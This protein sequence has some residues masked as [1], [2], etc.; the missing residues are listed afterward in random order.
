VNAQAPDAT[1]P[2]DAPALDA[3]E[4]AAWVRLAALVELLPAVLDSQLRRDAGLTHFEYLVLAM[5]ESAP[6]RVLRMSA[7]AARTSATLPRLSHV[8]SRMEGRG[9]VRRRPCPQ[10]GRASNV[11]LTDEG[12]AALRDASPGHEATVR[13]YVFDV[14]ERDQVHQ[15]TDITQAILRTIDPGGTMTALCQRPVPGRTA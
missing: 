5:L 4:A 2:A 10:D 12:E 1:R 7:L 15:L 6:D 8:V 9:L 11:E 13:R 3:A 14:L